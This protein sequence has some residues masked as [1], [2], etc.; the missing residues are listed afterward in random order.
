MLFADLLSL[1]LATFLM[2][3]FSYSCYITVEYGLNFSSKNL[4]A[5]SQAHAILVTQSKVGDKKLGRGQSSS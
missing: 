4:I 5:S 3:F 2:F 1:H